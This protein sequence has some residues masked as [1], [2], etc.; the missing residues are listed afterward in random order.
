MSFEFRGGGF[1]QKGQGFGPKG[2]GFSPG[3]NEDDP[4]KDTKYTGYLDEDMA[5]ELSELQKGFKERAKKERDRF[6]N[7]TDPGYWFSVYFSTRQEKEA[8]LKAMH[9]VKSMYGD[10]YIDGRKW[11]KQAGIDLGQD[12]SR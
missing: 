3:G 11:A 4:L 12:L 1:G 9:L 7:A 6:A 2:G 5:E 10:M 8:F